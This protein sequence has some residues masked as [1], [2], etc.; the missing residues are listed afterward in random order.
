MRISV[1]IPCYNGARFLRESLES[2]RAQTRPPEQVIVVDDGSTDDS[3]EIAARTRGVEL[4]RQANLGACLARNAGLARATGELLVFH[5]ADDRL[6]PHALEIGA[7]ALEARPE[8]AFVFGFNRKILADGRAPEEP[9]RAPL[10]DASYL[11]TLEGETLV[12]PGAAMFRR[13]RVAAAGGFRDGTF[14]TEDYD[15]YLRV[16]REAEIHCHNQVVVEYRAHG[17]NATSAG[18]SRTLRSVLRVL[19]D[20]RDFV[21]GRPELEQALERG[22]RHWGRVFG[23]RIAFE[24]VERIRRGQVVEAL[25]T[26]ALALRGHPRGLLAV[27]LHC[28]RIRAAG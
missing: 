10:G 20:Q 18:S 11:H 5:D 9:A 13:A 6:L 19:E 17:G 23:P 8:C 3:A 26:L 2:V 4:I 27:A 1:V 25:D 24:V 16:S 15:L 21:R 22:R 7:A 28:A 14:P 12:P